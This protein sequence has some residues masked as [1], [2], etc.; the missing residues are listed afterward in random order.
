MQRPVPLFAAQQPSE[1]ACFQCSVAAVQAVRAGLALTSADN[2][3]PSFGPRTDAR[4]SQDGTLFH[5]QE[6]AG[7]EYANLLLCSRAGAYA[8]PMTLT[9]GERWH[10]VTWVN[11]PVCY[12]F[13][14]TPPARC[15]RYKCEPGASGAGSHSV[16]DLTS[17]A[18]WRATGT[19]NSCDTA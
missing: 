17:R 7:S 4:K 14:W 9:G 1:S 19:F 18:S 10:K 16:E 13:A 3:R 5:Q 15:P 2:S 8:T 11:K 6:V 12:T